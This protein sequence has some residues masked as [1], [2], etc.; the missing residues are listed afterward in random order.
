MGTCL[1][2]PVSST[3]DTHGRSEQGPIDRQTDRHPFLFAKIL[4]VFPVQLENNPQAATA[5]R[6]KVF[7]SLW[8]NVQ[9]KRYTGVEA[10]VEYIYIF[11][12]NSLAI[13]IAVELFVFIYICE[14]IYCRSKR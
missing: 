12:N 5:D 1:D 10:N 4:P 8:V 9:G 13:P 14:H 3:R 2:F 6:L 11:K 7:F